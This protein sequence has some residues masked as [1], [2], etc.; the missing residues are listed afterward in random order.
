MWWLRHSRR[1]LIASFCAL[2]G[3]V[4]AGAVTREWPP[5]RGTAALA[6]SASSDN[7]PVLT[8]DGIAW[9]RKLVKNAHKVATGKVLSKPP[10]VDA[11]LAQAINL[12]A[13]VVKKAARSAALE[14]D[15]DFLALRDMI[16]NSVLGG[17]VAT[18]DD[19]VSCS[20]SSC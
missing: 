15:P 12:L 16:D 1:T 19:L 14:S 5:L 7:L 9:G 8:R 4:T 20:R 11:E 17:G 10:L 3:L 2:T 13:V 18:F 6:Q